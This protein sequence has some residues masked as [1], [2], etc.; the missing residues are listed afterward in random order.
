MTEET[1]FTVF[2]CAVV[3]AVGSL[4][5][6]AVAWLRL[7]S[8]PLWLVVLSA[9]ISTVFACVSAFAM[10]FALTVAAKR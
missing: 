1:N 8:G 4:F 5:F 10:G 7:E 3:T 9:G 2:E 6:M